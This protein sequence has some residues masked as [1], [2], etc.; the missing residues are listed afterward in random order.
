[1]KIKIKSWEEMQSIGRLE[2]VKH[3]SSIETQCIVFIYY[4]CCS[5]FWEQMKSL[6]GN[7]YNIDRNHLSISGWELSHWMFEVLEETT[8]ISLDCTECYYICDSCGTSQVTE[9][10]NYCPMCG[11]KITYY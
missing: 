3:V 10:H 1:M 4:N 7:I 2:T 6:C 9:H 5:V 11:L 8:T